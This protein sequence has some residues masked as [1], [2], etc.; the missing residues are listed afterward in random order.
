MKL[1]PM[2]VVLGMISVCFMV[3]GAFG[4]SPD[5]S[6]SK[7][8]SK[9]NP[10]KKF[11]EPV[12]CG[13]GG[14]GYTC[15]KMNLRW[16][17]VSKNSFSPN[18]EYVLTSTVLA[19]DIVD[20]PTGLKVGIWETVFTY[21]SWFDPKTQKILPSIP[22]AGATGLDANRISLFVM[23][24]GPNLDDTIAVLSG[25]S[26]EMLPNSTL[27]RV[28][29]LDHGV[30]GGTGA[31]LGAVGVLHSLDGNYLDTDPKHPEGF[32]KIWVPKLPDI[33]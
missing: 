7:T 13:V 10:L 16:V 14:G 5:L 28:T 4:A 17:P 15:Y 3:V 24:F 8:V 22:P 12:K 30:V 29:D 1:F 6:P 31:F 26:N 11:Y 23:E 9:Y 18:K 27:G 25:A 20:V 32:M 2:H 21:T 33:P 19:G